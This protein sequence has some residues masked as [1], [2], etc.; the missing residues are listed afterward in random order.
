MDETGVCVVRL[1]QPVPRAGEEVNRVG[2]PGPG[3]R[4]LIGG[5]QFFIRTEGSVHDRVL[6]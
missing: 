1:V 2:A 5:G 4:P 3:S 6:A